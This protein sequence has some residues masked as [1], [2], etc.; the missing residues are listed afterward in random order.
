MDSQ[1]QKSQEPQAPLFVF[2]P[3]SLWDSDSDSMPLFE[4]LLGMSW[5]EQEQ[6][7]DT[8]QGLL[9]ARKRED[10]DSDD[11]DP[12]TKRRR[13]EESY[14]PDP[15]FMKLSSGEEF[16]FTEEDGKDLVNIHEPN[17]MLRNI[18]ADMPRKISNR[19]RYLAK[20]NHTE[21]MEG[22]RHFENVYDAVIAGYIRECR[23]RRIFRGVLQRWRI[24]KMN[25]ASTALIDPI[26]LSPPERTVTVYDW[27]TRKRYL[28]D[29]KSLATLIDSQLLYN[30]YGFSVPQMP[31]NPWTNIEF[32]Y[33][34]LV[35]MYEQLRYHGELRWGF[36]TLRSHQFHKEAWE[37]Y[38]RPAL[39]MKAIRASMIQ[40][41]TRAAREML[42]DFIIRQMEECNMSMTDNILHIYSLAIQHVPNHW[43]LQ[44]FKS[45]ACQF[46]EAEQFG[47][48]APGILSACRALFKKQPQFVRELREAG[49]IVVHGIV[50]TS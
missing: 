45:L 20:F 50:H 8:Q 44:S 2:H 24:R 30:E 10:S 29:A 1:E 7:Q 3:D 33:I 34:Q 43:Y 27:A 37:L 6:E 40:L 19:I 5:R 28:F 17:V 42:E 38:H 16:Y 36:T 39:T 41:D 32:T 11:E 22:P 9:G 12:V 18:I 35:S 13:C 21:I 31:R 15:F 49:V 23:L 14:E 4:V 48:R 26:T 47:V 46:W 25:R